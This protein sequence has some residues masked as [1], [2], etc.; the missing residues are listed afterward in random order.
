MFND[1]NHLLILNFKIISFRSFYF[2]YCLCEVSMTVLQKFFFGNRAQR[3]H[4]GGQRSSNP[5]RSGCTYCTYCG[6]A[7]GAVSISPRCLDA[8]KNQRN[9]LVL[10][11][12]N[13]TGA[14][15]LAFVDRADLKLY[16][17][18]PRREAIHQILHSCIRDLTKKLVI[19]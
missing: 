7:E 11:T 10:T 5:A 9:V 14:I 19:L 2:L 6:I 16:V 12:S 15:D 4:Q 13:I 3:L 18:P 1:R 8:M 17:G